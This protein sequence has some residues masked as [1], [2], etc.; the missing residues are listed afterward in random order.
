MHGSMSVHEMRCTLIAAGP[1]FRQ[2]VVS[3]LPTG[4]VDVAPTVLSLLG[5]GAPLGVEGRI[6]EEAMSGAA[7]IASPSFD[8]RE[9]AAARTLPCGEYSQR[10]SVSRVGRTAYV[11]YGAAPAR[12]T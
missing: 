9:H 5:L 8:T 6:L 2:A 3:D 4:N 12:E 7:Q 11:N 10:I 1:D